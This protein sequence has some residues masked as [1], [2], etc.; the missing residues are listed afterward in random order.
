MCHLGYSR[1]TL[2]LE[3]TLRLLSF[4]RRRTTAPSAP[5]HRRSKQ[6]VALL[7]EQEIWEAEIEWYDQFADLIEALPWFGQNVPPIPR[8]Q[9]GRSG[10]LT[11]EDHQRVFL[12][13]L[14]GGSTSIVASRAGVSRRT[15]YA[16][17]ERL[18]YVSDPAQAMPYWRDLGLIEC[19]ATPW[20]REVKGSAWQEVICLICHRNVVSYDWI[21]VRL[22]AGEVFRPDP[23]RQILGYWNLERTPGRTQGHLIL[24]FWLDKDPLRTSP[25]YDHFEMGVWSRVPKRAREYLREYRRVRESVTS[26]VGA[27]DEQDYER[28]RRWRRGL[29]EAG[30]VG[31]I[32]S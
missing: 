9:R 27:R 17:L 24:H 30:K 25:L 8:S 6:S 29:F 7:S 20:R 18:I 22:K 16:V 3:I 5:S 4:F 23:K 11:S 21:N 10:R 13:W 19:L 2:A 26:P 12:S 31:P 15:I 14:T 1:P 28:W 32:P